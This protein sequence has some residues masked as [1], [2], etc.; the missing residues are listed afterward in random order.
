MKGAVSASEHSRFSDPI[1]GAT[2]HQM[3]RH[4]SI[5]HPAYFLQS[6]FTPDG[7]HVLFTSYRTGAPQLFEAGFPN[8]DIRQLTDG[9][10]IHP[11]SP[12]IDPDGE[13]VFFVRGA[14]IW[15]VHRRTLQE[16]EIIDFPGAQLG[17]CSLGGG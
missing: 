5:N 6:S 2:V 12:A 1:T 14:S 10:A 9:P 13:L 8:G 17:E 4:A 16:K 11:F 3:T 15:S 7:S